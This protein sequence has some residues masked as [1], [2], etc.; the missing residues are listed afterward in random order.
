MSFFD[1]RCKIVFH[2]ICLIG[3]L[4]GSSLFQDHSADARLVLLSLTEHP[5]WI[6]WTNGAFPKA[7]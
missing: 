6:E 3:I 4:N 7:K 2:P 5:P 1:T